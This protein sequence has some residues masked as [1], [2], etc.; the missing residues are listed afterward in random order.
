MS[1]KNYTCKQCGFT[2]DGAGFHGRLC[3][4][5]RKLQRNNHYVENREAIINIQKDYYQDNKELI[6]SQ[7][8]LY[9]QDNRNLIL[10]NHKEYERERL[11]KDPVFKLRKQVSTLIRQGFKKEG[12]SKF[13]KSVMKYIPYSMSELRTHLESQFEIW[14]NWSNHGKYNVDLWNDNDQATWTW[15]LDH[16]VP[17]ADL[18][19]QSMA[20]ENFKQCWSLS[21]LRPLS[22][23]QNLLDGVL[24]VRH[25]KI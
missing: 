6:K 19:Y 25:G 7:K 20:D 24:R 21:N 4:G 22:S 5:C 1:K 3:S 2:N 16:I 10:S 23:K 13:N 17:Q 12:L 18:P 11:Q 15:Q 8:K 9:Y 14:M